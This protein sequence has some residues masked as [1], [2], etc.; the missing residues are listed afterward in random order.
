[1]ARNEILIRGNA[2]EQNELITNAAARPGSLME[3][4][5]TGYRLHQSAG[6]A[7]IVA[8]LKEQHERDGNDIDDNVLQNDKGT[9][10]FPEL[11]AVVNF[12]TADTIARGEWVESAG[13]GAVRV[14]GSGYRIGQAV[15]ASDLSG[16]VGRVKVVICPIG[17]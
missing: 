4:T 9:I 10:L 6:G 7:A 3:Q 12:V 2:R 11:G 14:F 5:A 16:S 15:E 13:A 17:L 8:V 1:M